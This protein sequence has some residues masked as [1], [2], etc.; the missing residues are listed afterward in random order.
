M[1]LF[2]RNYGIALLC[3]ASTIILQRMN[4]TESENRILCC[5]E[6]Q[7]LVQVIIREF[8]QHLTEYDSV[9]SVSLINCTKLN[10]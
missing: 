10:L 4:D 6:K 7:A 1:G 5:I 8:A 2:S 3:M 9:A